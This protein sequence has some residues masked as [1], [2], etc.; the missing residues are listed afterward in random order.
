MIFKQS[1]YAL[2]KQFVHGRMKMS[3]MQDVFNAI[4]MQLTSWLLLARSQTYL[5]YPRADML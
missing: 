5:I 2:D 4:N 3:S 1:G